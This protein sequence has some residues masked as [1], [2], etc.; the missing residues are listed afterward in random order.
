[1]LV[2]ARFDV[3]VEAAAEFGERA[4][5]ALGALAARPGWVRGRV[6]RSTDDPTR[7]VL[8]GEW[9]D[10]GAYRRALSAYEVKLHA[11]P[12]LGLAIDE[13]TGFEVLV[14]SDEPVAPVLRSDS[15]RSVDAATVAVG[16]AAGPPR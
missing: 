6:G 15:A 4:R 2:V 13:V 16:E 11:A 1:M 14:R 12:L 3:A 5:A 10:V 7:W 8:V 9:V